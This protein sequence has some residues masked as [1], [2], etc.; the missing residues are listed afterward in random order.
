MTCIVCSSEIAQN[1]WVYRYI[2]HAHIHT[3]I[4]SCLLVCFYSSACAF[5]NLFSEFYYCSWNQDQYSVAKTLAMFHLHSSS[6]WELRNT[7]TIILRRQIHGCCIQHSFNTV[8][9]ESKINLVLKQTNTHT[10]IK[11]ALRKNK[12]TA[13]EMLGLTQS[14]LSLYR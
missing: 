5:W 7:T 8:E 1:C 2:L 9:V 3:A 14:I 11:L 12:A 4:W 6:A 10:H 13:S